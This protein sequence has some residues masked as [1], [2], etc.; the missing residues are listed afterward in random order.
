MTRTGLVLTFLLLATLPGCL[1][2]REILSIDATGRIEVR[3]EISG[4]RGDLDGGAAALPAAPLWRTSRSERRRDDGEEEVIL[5]AEADFTG[6]EALPGSFSTGAGALRFETSLVPTSESRDRRVF[7]FR[8][9]YRARPWADYAR[10]FRRLVPEDLRDRFR[11]P[12]DLGKLE[13]PDRE[14]GLQVL[15][16]YEVAKMVRWTREALERLPLHS[17]EVRILAGDRAQEALEAWRR[18]E[19]D[20]A[21]VAALRALDEGAMVARCETLL[22]AAE[23]VL[24]AAVAEVAAPHPDWDAASFERLRA[25][26]KRD[27]EVTEDLQDESFELI[28]RLPGRVLSA[29][30]GEATDEGLVFRFEGRDL[31][32]RDQLIE[33]LY[34]LPRP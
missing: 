7:L 5:R 25:E 8:R 1:K 19:L 31:L 27:F 21:A 26:A 3:H 6:A 17:A 34:E 11:R 15:V 23:G 29:G 24:R 30:G 22:A 2:R 32:D 12:E 4:D 20:P 28:L 33:V 9:R 10:L 16:D 14:R 13:G 18:R